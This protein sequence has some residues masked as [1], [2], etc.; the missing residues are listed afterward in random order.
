MSD[1]HIQ[2]ESEMTEEQLLF[3][4]TRRISGK[5]LGLV[6]GFLC[7][8]TLWLATIWLVIKGGPNVGQHLGLISQ[9]FPGYSVT[10]AGSFLG[11]FYG[12]AFGFISAWS[13]GKIYNSVVDMKLKK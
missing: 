10:F 3:H 4:A 12:F 7:G 13:L 11:L 5:V 2:D 8:F 1:T 9:F 6:F